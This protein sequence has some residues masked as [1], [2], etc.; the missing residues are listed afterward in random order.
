VRT[1][2][3]P[4]EAMGSLTARHGIAP[5]RGA[6]R[7][8]DPAIRTA[9]WSRFDDAIYVKRPSET[10]FSSIAT[11]P[12]PG[13]SRSSMG[14]GSRS[15]SAIAANRGRRVHHERTWSP[16]AVGKILQAVP[17]ASSILRAAI[18]E[19]SRKA[20]RAPFAAKNGRTIDGRVYLPPGFTE[21]ARATLPGDVYYY[22]GTNPV[23]RDSADVTKEWWAAPGS[24]VR[25]PTLR[26]TGY[27]Q[28]LSAVHV[29][30]WG[31]V[32]SEEILDVTRAFLAAYPAV[33][34]KR[35]GCI[36]ASYG[37]F[38]TMLLVTKTDLFAAAVSHAGISN[39]ASYWG[40]GYWGYSYGSARDR[41][42]FPWNRK[43]LYVEQS[44]LFHADKVKTPF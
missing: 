27:G 37:G 15:R 20:R 31:Q 44:P 17:L 39:L 21:S 1:I 12:R 8:F 41:D 30:D 35:V 16:R 43:E 5:G 4:N 40:E 19:R 25:A 36:G 42:S 7:E 32:R 38:M 24:G 29:N 18:F 23:E 2:D 33:D 34:A 13:A 28:A 11:T 10:A 22:G 9:T 6:F 3:D 14:R 26:A